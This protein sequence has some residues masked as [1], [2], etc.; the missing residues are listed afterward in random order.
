MAFALMS[1]KCLKDYSNQSSSCSNHQ[2][3]K[4]Y[5]SNESPEWLMWSFHLKSPE[6]VAMNDVLTP[7]IWYPCLQLHEKV[8]VRSLAVTA[9]KPIQARKHVA[10][11]FS[12]PKRKPQRENTWHEKIINL[13][14]QLMTHELRDTVLPSRGNFH[15]KKVQKSGVEEENKSPRLLFISCYL[16]KSAI[17]VAIGLNQKV[18]C[19]E[20]CSC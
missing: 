5:G 20:W 18:W 6:R 4:T 9:V 8:H 15:I 7:N 11:A 17:K 1:A 13:I 10:S 19:I 14:R 3:V 12:T 16:C 2:T